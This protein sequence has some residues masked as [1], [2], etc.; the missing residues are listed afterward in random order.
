[1]TGKIH[2][3]YG[4][5]KGKTT[6]AVGLSVRAV[7]AGKRVIFTQFFK[8]GSS[9]EIKSLQYLPTIQIMHCNTVPGRF[10]RMTEEQRAQATQ[11]YSQLLENALTAAED[12]DLLVLDEAVSACNHGIISETRLIHFLRNRPEA[13]E[14]VLTGRDPSDCLLELADYATEMQKQKHPF[15]QG[16][17]AR[18]GIEF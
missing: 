5:G 14:V 1:M 18:K 15:D 11:D 8:N 10:A 13:L 17:R 12:A 6:A 9:S 2:L 7:G 4:N 16:I 3:Y